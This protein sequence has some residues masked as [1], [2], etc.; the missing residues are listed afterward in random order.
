MLVPVFQGLR[1]RAL[2]RPDDSRNAMISVL[3]MVIRRILED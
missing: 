1:L 3:R 2:R